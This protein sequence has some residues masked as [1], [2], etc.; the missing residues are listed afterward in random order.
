MFRYIDYRIRLL[1]NRNK[2]FSRYFHEILLE[3]GIYRPMSDDPSILFFTVHRCASTFL[4]SVFDQ[5]LPERMIHINFD[6]YF[7]V[8]NNDKYKLYQSPEF[9]SDAFQSKGYF[10]GPFRN[11]V[12]VSNLSRFKIILILRDPRDVLT[13]HYYSAAF[14]HPEINDKLIL[15]R[16][17]A[18]RLTVDEYVIA[19]SAE[20]RITYEHYLQHLKGRENV[21]LIRYEDMITDYPGFLNALSSVLSIDQKIKDQLIKEDPFKVAE[22]DKFSHKRKVKAG[23]YLDKLKPETIEILNS[24]FKSIIKELGY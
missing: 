12:P 24:E 11:Y 3:N 22:E 21:Q 5:I 20:F 1:F 8:V 17:K 18:L 2:H 16:E 4:T 9:L 13:S 19:K 14:S 7:S 6:S 23:D 15:G 10:Y